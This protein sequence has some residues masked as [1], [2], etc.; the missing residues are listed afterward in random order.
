MK[1][2]ELLSAS[3][4]RYEPFGVFSCRRLEIGIDTAESAA[5]SWHVVDPCAAPGRDSRS[6]R[7]RTAAGSPPAASCMRKVV[8]MQNETLFFF[9]FRSRCGSWKKPLK[10][11]ENSRRS[12]NRKI[13]VR[14]K[15]QNMYKDMCSGAFSLSASRGIRGAR[16]RSSP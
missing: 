9:R 1:R 15:T 10:S 3:A 14:K 4:P 2:V 12:W 13:S 5:R 8:R 7:V 6:T 16:L 11:E